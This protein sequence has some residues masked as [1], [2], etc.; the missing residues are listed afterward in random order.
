MCVCVRV[1]VRVRVRVHVHVNVP[2]ARH[3]GDPGGRNRGAANL[4]FQLG[5]H[6]TQ[7]REK[8]KN[9]KALT[10]GERM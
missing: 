4:S 5:E 6:H 9:N 10:M 3:K 7:Q 8:K 2:K 1:C